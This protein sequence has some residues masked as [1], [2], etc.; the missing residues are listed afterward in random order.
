M[1]QIWQMDTDKTK[2]K[3]IEQPNSRFSRGDAEEKKK[4]G[5]ECPCSVI[6]SKKNSV[7]CEIFVSFVVKRIFR[8]LAL[9]GELWDTEEM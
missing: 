6:F 9:W 8:E 5:Q 7:L 4:G 1:T 2:K 3:K